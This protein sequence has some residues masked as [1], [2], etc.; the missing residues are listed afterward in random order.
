MPNA[1]TCPQCGARLAMRAPAQGQRV[2]CSGCGQIFGA[3][4]TAAEQADARGQFQSR[5]ARP[6][7]VHV[8]PARRSQRDEE[9]EMDDRSP[10]SSE[11]SLG[12]IVGLAVGGGLLV[13][14]LVV[15][16]IVLVAAGPEEA[17]APV[18]VADHGPMVLPLPQQPP[19]Q[20][21]PWAQ[22]QPV[23]IPP[24]QLPPLPQQPLPPV[25]Q[26]LDPDPINRA[27]A[28]L[29]SVIQLLDHGD[30]NVQL[31]AVVALGRLKDARAADA[32]A[33]LEAWPALE[34]RIRALADAPDPIF[35][36]SRSGEYQWV[37]MAPV[38][39]DAQAF[40]RRISFGNIVAIHNDQR[41]IY[42]ESGR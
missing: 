22:P 41:L 19:V 32:L 21:P 10:D 38:N 18:L 13:I 39:S 29:K 40:A 11:R 25:A 14:G 27:L 30:G 3:G 42:V 7:A 26:P 8:V 28:A 5:Q 20:V 35:K 12:L 2:R 23:Q 6:P 16:L 31:A 37:D 4:V 33:D 36:V 34:K 15:T 17:P 9:G 1:T 24:L